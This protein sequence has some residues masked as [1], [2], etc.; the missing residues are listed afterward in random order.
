[1][2][3]TPDFVDYVLELARVAGRASARAMFGGHGVYLDGLIVGI[4]IDDVLYLKS[5]D[6]T[7]EAF[8]ARQLPAFE[9]VDRHGKRTVMSYRLAP[10]EVLE[11]PEAM[12]DWMRL[13]KEAALRAAAAKPRKA[14]DRPAVTRRA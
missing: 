14:K 10:D 13:A 9:Y 7:V 12:R 6:A 4:V 2:P 3:N 1:M 11:S 5:D 8:E